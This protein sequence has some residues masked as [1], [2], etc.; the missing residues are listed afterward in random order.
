[1]PNRVFE[2]DD[3]LVIFGLANDLRRLMEEMEG[4]KA[5]KLKS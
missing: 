3:I 4:V 5:E 1:M 2:E